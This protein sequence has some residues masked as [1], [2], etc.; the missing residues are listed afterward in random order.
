MR[1]IV[2]EQGDGPAVICWGVDPST[3]RVAIA[4]SHDGQGIVV[5]TRSFNPDLRRG[6]RVIE[7]LRET[8]DHAQEMAEHWPPDRIYVE[9]PVVYGDRLEVELYFATGAVLA[10]LTS[11]TGLDC[12]IVP[13]SSWKKLTTGRGNIK[14]HELPAAARALG[15]EGSR[16]DEA[17]AWLI[18][19]AGYKIQANEMNAGL[20]LNL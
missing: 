1:V 9:Q 7:I 18:A 15:Y 12:E 20:Q 14:K 19:I 8:R 17:D 13:P 3:K 5:E 16:P 10:G 4:A 11:A 2:L 6:Q